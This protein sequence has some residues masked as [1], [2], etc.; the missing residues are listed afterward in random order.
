MGSGVE[1]G[2]HDDF[3]GVK[4]RLSG[5][6]VEAVLRGCGEA[7]E[8]AGGEGV[9]E[10]SDAAHVE[11]GILHGYLGGEDG[12]GLGGGHGHLGYEED[13]AESRRYGDGR[14]DEAVSVV[15]YYLASPVERCGGVVGVSLDSRSQ[16]EHLGVAQRASEQLVGGDDPRD[17]GG[18]AAAKSASQGYLVGAGEPDGRDGFADLLAGKLERP[19]NEVVGA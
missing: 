2:A 18:G 15:Y 5:G 3:H 8:I 6:L 16:G 9:D 1:G 10:E 14:G 17:R 4:D 13:G 11:D 7:V 19:R 12:A